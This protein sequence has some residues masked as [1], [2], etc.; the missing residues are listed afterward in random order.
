MYLGINSVYV[1]RGAQRLIRLR[2]EDVNAMRSLTSFGMVESQAKF[3]R[4][5][6][7]GNAMRQLDTGK[8]VNGKIR[9]L[10]E[11][12]DCIEPALIWYGQRHIDTQPELAETNDIG[13]VKVLEPIIVGNVQ[14]DRFNAL[15]L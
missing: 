1:T 12:K 9:T 10:N 11:R 6:E 5:I 15:R 4:H 14:K 13:E 3:E 2:I 8:I 7:A